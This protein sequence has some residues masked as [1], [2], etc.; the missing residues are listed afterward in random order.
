MVSWCKGN[1]T[2][3]KIILTCAVY[4]T[5]LL[6]GNVLRYGGNMT[7][8]SIAIA[9]PSHSC[10]VQMTLATLGAYPLLC[11]RLWNVLSSTCRAIAKG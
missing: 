9:E 10:V 8:V 1:G 11:H 2:Y 3:D 6:G 4:M 5:G 7:G